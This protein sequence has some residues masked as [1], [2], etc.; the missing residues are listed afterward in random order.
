MFLFLIFTL[1]AVY[2]YSW[3]TYT[4]WFRSSYDVMQCIAININTGRYT[5]FLNLLSTLFSFRILRHKFWSCIKLIRFTRLDP[6]KTPEQKQTRQ[7]V[8]EFG[9]PPGV[10]GTGYLGHKNFV[11]SSGSRFLRRA[12][13]RD[14]RLVFVKKSLVRHR[15]P[16][17]KVSYVNLHTK[18]GPFR[19]FFQN[20][21]ALANWFT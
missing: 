9:V 16:L 7:Y 4:L 21:V 8:Q 11:G 20:T 6:S 5:E 2:I 3:Q 1:K 10:K 14:T 13:Q 15:V 18:S 12:H 19:I 17:S